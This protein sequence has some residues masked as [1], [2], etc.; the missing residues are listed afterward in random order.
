MGIDGA[1][2]L[3]V[4]KA[5]SILESNWNDLISAGGTLVEWGG[6][7][8]A[9]LAAYQGGSGQGS[10]SVSRPVSFASSSIPYNLHLTGLSD[11]DQ[12]LAGTNVG[13]LQDFDGEDRFHDQPLHGADE[14]TRLT[15]LTMDLTV[16]LG[17]P[18]QT[19]TNQMATG[20]NSDG[21]LE[22]N[23]LNNPYDGSAQDCGGAA[24]CTG[25]VL[26]HAA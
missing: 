19:A 23:A 17:G 7:S 16:F 18:F 11:G 1:P 21:H 15:N 3:R 22:A 25:W 26:Y 14:A 20:L 13:I 10:N 9:N 5:L 8:Y 2:A 4:N 12:N 24:K 6:T